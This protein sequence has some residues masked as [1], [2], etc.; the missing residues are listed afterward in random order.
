MFTIT[1]IVAKFKVGKSY[2]KINVKTVLEA[3]L[4][5]SDRVPLCS[6]MI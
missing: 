1:N 5:V 6:L 4:L 2:L 3:S